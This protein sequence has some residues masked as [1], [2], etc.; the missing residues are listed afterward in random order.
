MKRMATP[1][2]VYLRRRLAIVAS[3]LA[4]AGMAVAVSVQPA[5]PEKV[6]HLGAGAKREL[7]AGTWHYTYEDVGVRCEW[8]MDADGI[9]ATP[10]VCKERG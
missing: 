3:G 9:R 2:C 6:Q 8:S 10:T 7:I 4:L 1:S 5:E